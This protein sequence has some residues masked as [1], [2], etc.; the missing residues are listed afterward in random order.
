[1]T[2]QFRF[3]FFNTIVS[4]GGTVVAQ[5][6]GWK[7][8]KITLER[9]PN[10]HSLIEYFRGTFI[11]YGTALAFIQTVK[12]T[13]GPEA[14]LRVL[15]EIQFNFVY[16]TFF[17][18][19]IGLDAAEFLRHGAVIN[20]CSAPIIRNDLWAKFLSRKSIPVN[21]QAAFD[22][23]G[24]AQTTV[25]KITVPLPSQKIKSLYNGSN[26]SVRDGSLSSTIE[27]SLA[28]NEYGILDFT[29]ESRTEISTKYHYPLF[30]S[31]DQP[32]PLFFVA[33]G[34]DYTFDIF[35]VLAGNNS[36]FY[37]TEAG[38]D[39][40]LATG[41]G[42]LSNITLTRTD[43]GLDGTDGRTEY[44]YSGTIALVKGDTIRLYIKNTSGGALITRW[45]EY[46]NFVSDVPHYVSYLN[47]IADTV[48]DDSETDAYL[49]Q[50]AAKSILNKIT[51]VYNVLISTVLSACKGLNIMMLGKHVRGYLFSELAINIS[52]DDYW[53]SIEPLYNLGFGYTD[54]GGLE[55]ELKDDFYNL[56]PSV[57]ISNV[58]DMVDK[59]DLEKYYKSVTIGAEKWSAES[60]DGID[61]PQ[62][63]HTYEFGFP[64]IGRDFPI[65]TKAV[66]AS[67]AI[68]QTRRNVR[69][70]GKDW[71]L[72]EDI[73]VIAV[74]SDG[75]GGYI[76]EDGTDFAAITNLNNSDT[77]YN[78]R[79]TP[80]RMFKRWQ[81]WLAGCKQIDPA[82]NF[83]FA[84]GEGNYLMTSQF[85]PADCEAVSNPDPVLAENQNIVVGGSSTFIPRI[86]AG[87]TPMQWS[88]YKTIRTARKQ[89]IAV[90]STDKDFL[91]MFIKTLSYPVV[92]GYANFEALLGSETTVNP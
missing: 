55:I 38:I 49:I 25:N 62:T 85:D 72:D 66:I 4:P 32:F 77:R 43:V 12:T 46:T 58:P 5:P 14:L 78:I 70:V 68:E 47:I 7:D 61:D 19:L 2:P 8:A 87:K 67:L 6:G 57:F 56:T 81:L 10:F 33:Y 80:A 89:A 36:M 82:G 50:D 30:V 3:T 20:R 16:E 90:S 54:T 76:P 13:Q 91:R 79:H 29:K 92:G 69:E 15:V 23:D 53:K 34:G 24:N 31:V 74:K 1:M 11:W 59:S 9:D 84:K 26:E 73:M 37:K 35:I 75:M 42:V 28:N 40:I 64:T 17:D 65:R 18:G 27:Y 63:S 44:T 45:I 86:F 71:K 51:G 52:F 48:Y 83:N 39:V 41:G 88:V 22:L 21:L 60:G